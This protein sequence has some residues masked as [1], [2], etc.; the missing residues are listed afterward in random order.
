MFMLFIGGER[1]FVR[2]KVW[3]NG[4]FAS[5]GLSSVCGADSGRVGWPIRYHQYDNRYAN[6]HQCENL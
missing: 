6:L 3:Q 5:C 1:R 4:S 2:S